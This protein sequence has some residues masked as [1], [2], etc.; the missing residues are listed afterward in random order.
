M[1]NPFYSILSLQEWS[2]AGARHTI[3]KVLVHLN[4]PWRRS[5]DPKSG[6]GVQ[7]LTTTPIGFSA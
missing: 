6:R 3:S 2:L 5:Q 1:W 7:L 4:P